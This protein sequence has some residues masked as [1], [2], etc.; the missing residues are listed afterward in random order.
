MQYV[1]YCSLTALIVYGIWFFKNL[2]ASQR[3]KQI[4]RQYQKLLDQKLL[5]LRFEKTQALVGG[6]ERTVTYKRNPLQFTLR[7]ETSFDA[8]YM[9]ATNDKQ[10]TT[11]VL[12]RS[13]SMQ[14]TVIKTLEEWL[15]KN[16]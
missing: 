3:A 5:P 4:H 7:Y 12:D 6:R 9:D 1:L 8:N 2:A 10:G 15:V 14:T 16:S 11:L 13:A